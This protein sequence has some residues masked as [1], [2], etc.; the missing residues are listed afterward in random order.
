MLVNCKYCNLDFSKFSV[1][2]KANHSRWCVE[3]PNRGHWKNRKPGECPPQFK[4][5]EI[6]KKRAEGIKKAHAR[7]AYENVDRRTWIGRK[8]TESSKQKMREAALKSRHRRLVRGIVEYNGVMLDSSWELILAKRLDELK[9][10]WIRPS[11]PLPW[12]DD[13]GISHNYFPDFYLPD[14]NLYL[15]PKN[16]IAKRVQKK[17]LD[18]VLTKYPNVCILESEEECKAYVPSSK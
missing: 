2:E 7:G 14:Y 13:E 17:K 9:I 11:E 15:D 6:I 4:G 8:H 5:K 18:I 12:E 1:S 10:K 16:P 3:N